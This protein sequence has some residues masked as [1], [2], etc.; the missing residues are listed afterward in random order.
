[1]GEGS[2]AGP[3]A[4]AESRRA[5]LRDCG[6]SAGADPGMDRFARLVTRLLD[7][8]AAAVVLVAE[9]RQLLPGL[10]GL[11]VPRVTSLGESL[12]WQTVPAAEPMAVA[13]VETDARWSAHPAVGAFGVGAYA[14]IALT[15]S[16]G[17]VLGALCALDGVPREWPADALRDLA[18]LAAACGAELRLRIATRRS[19]RTRALVEDADR[20]IAEQA[21]GELARSRLLLRAAED[22]A[23][24]TTLADVRRQLRNLVASD[25]EPAYVGLTVVEGRR[26]RRL[27]DTLNREPVE[28]FETYDLDDGW[29]SARAARDSEIIVINGAYDLVDGGYSEDTVTAFT[30]HGLNTAICVPLPGTRLPL[31][32]LILGWSAPRRIDVTEKALLTA[33]AGYVAHAVERALYVDERVGVAHELQRAMLTELPPVT[34]LELAGHYRP[35]AAGQLVGGDWYDAYPLPGHERVLAVTI[36]DITGHNTAAAALMGQTRSMLRQ[37]D[38]DLL[39]T[40]PA[41]AVSALER[42]NDALGIG[43]S[44]TL[45]HAHLRPLDGGR[46]EFAWTNAGHLPPLVRRPGGEIRQLDENDV[47]LHYA[48]TQRPRTTRRITLDPGSAVLLYT[49]GLVDRAGGDID[50]DIAAVAELFAGYDGGPLDGLLQV[51]ADRIGGPGPEDDIALL[52]VR[53]PGR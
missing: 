44:G 38:V 50:A 26:V 27:V 25:L 24:A 28:E 14:G 52:A 21:R 46:W 15:D 20:R 10:S 12:C 1:M 37:A 41:S 32:S 7:V 33:V 42:A 11:D 9:D 18:D 51:V 39:G 23:D 19:G 17:N 29:P 31:G 48:L 35:A 49:D 3:G 43:A 53:V 45:V 16:D 8:P 36:G 4:R 34:G 40:D 47:M 6:L 5:A 2:T 22:L 30:A 13:D